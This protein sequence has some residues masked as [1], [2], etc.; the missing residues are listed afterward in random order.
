MSH[1]PSPSGARH[2]IAYNWPL[3]LAGTAVAVG[4]ALAGRRLRGAARAAVSAAAGAGAWW[5]AA[6][7][8]ASFA[9]YDR[10]PLHDW[11]WLGPTLARAGRPRDPGRHMVVL[12]SF[13]GLN[14][15]FVRSVSPGA[16]GMAVMA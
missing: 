14:W 8:V 5:T 12:P 9:V 15:S 2:V 6:S 1:R 13:S 3:Y 4:G 11:T 7:L 16:L 10:S